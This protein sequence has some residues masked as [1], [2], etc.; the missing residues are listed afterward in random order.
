MDSSEAGTTVTGA[1]LPSVADVADSSIVAPE[2]GTELSG[3]VTPTAARPDVASTI[4]TSITRDSVSL[5]T[6]AVPSATESSITSSHMVVVAQGAEETTSAD[7]QSDPIAIT[8]DASAT[9]PKVL[10]GLSASL[11]SMPQA[12]DI[13]P[14][15]A[16]PETTTSPA[17]TPTSTGVTHAPTPA[18]KISSVNVNKKFL[19]KGAAPV[20]IVKPVAVASG[21]FCDRLN[22]SQLLTAVVIQVV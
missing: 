1:I 6:T 19:E 11:A 22:M 14:V 17:L 9:E 12:S 2:Q 15:L 3:E 8:V 21:A 16:Q 5:A 20:G 13:S 7:P 10:S 4:P 18:K